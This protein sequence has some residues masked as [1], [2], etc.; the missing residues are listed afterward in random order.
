MSIPLQILS[1]YACT[2]TDIDRVMLH[3]LFLS[4]AVFSF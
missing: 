2:H 4:I 1:L 3:T